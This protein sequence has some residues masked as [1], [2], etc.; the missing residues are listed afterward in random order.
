MYLLRAGHGLPAGTVTGAASDRLLQ[1]IGQL[2]G[3]LG[4]HGGVTDERMS[5]M[6]IPPRRRWWNPALVD[7]HARRVR[8]R[9][10]SDHFDA[11]PLECV[12]RTDAASARVFRSV[13]AARAFATR[14]RCLAMIF[15]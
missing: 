4:L 10:Q 3:R 6:E 9:L 7:G 13:L 14:L 5:I 11:Q 15:W 12:E 1:V 2:D 8:E